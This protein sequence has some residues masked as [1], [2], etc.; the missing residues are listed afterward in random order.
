M[1]I[2]AFPATGPYPDALYRALRPL[3]AQV[4]EGEFTRK[5][6]SQAQHGDIVHLHWPS[7]LYASGL[8]RLSI[9]ASVTRFLILLI[10]TRLRGVRIAWTAHNLYPHEPT[11]VP[12][13]DAI[14]RRVVVRLAEAIFVHGPSAQRILVREF[15]NCIHK[16]VLI[17]HGHWVGQYCGSHTRASARESFGI[18]ADDYVYLFFG[19]CR[20]YKNLSLLIETFSTMP[21]ECRLIIAGKFQASAYKQEITQLVNRLGGRRIKLDADHIP[22]EDVQRYFAA[23]DSVVLPYRETLTSG[24][25]VLAMSLGLPVVAPDKG[26]LSDLVTSVCG[27]LYPLEQTNGLHQA[28]TNIRERRFSETVIVE[29]VKKHRWEDAARAMFDALSLKS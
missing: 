27:E 11:P 20:P 4:I 1:K 19:M 16:V 14:V 17:T 13:A 8:S 26:F 5:G 2:F 24:G 15:P 7:Y 25:A 28:M 22:D 21:E 3:G 6:L 18:A 29:T 9:A 12:H 23:A 10:Y